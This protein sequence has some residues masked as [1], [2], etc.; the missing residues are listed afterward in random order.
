M[1]AV[2]AEQDVVLTKVGTD[3]GGDC[4]FAN[5]RVAGAMNHAALM[6]A[7]QMFFALANQLHRA[8][9]RQ[10]SAGINCLRS[11]RAWE[12]AGGVET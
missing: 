4:L 3:T 5:V 12:R 2:R 8:I 10:Y 9:E 1:T 11:H 7:G 6:A